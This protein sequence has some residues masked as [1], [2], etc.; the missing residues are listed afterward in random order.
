MTEKHDSNKN[1]R[2]FIVKL[3]YIGIPLITMAFGTMAGWHVKRLYSQQDLHDVLIR[4][5]EISIGILSVRAVNVEQNLIEFKGQFRE[6]KQTLD[7]MNTA[8]QIIASTLK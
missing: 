5:H 2:T 7:S 1:G 4:S 8:L 6:A 3:F